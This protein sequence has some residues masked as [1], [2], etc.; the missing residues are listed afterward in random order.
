MKGSFL[1]SSMT[2]QGTKLE[3]TGDRSKAILFLM[4]SLWLANHGWYSSESTNKRQPPSFSI[5]V[6]ELTQKTA[7]IRGTKW[8]FLSVGLLRSGPRQPP[9]PAS[10]KPNSQ[11][12]FALEYGLMRKR[13]LTTVD[14]YNRRRVN[15][16]PRRCRSNL[17]TLNLLLTKQALDMFCVPTLQ[18]ATPALVFELKAHEEC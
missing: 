9:T 15:S 10:G 13:R 3:P 6:I 8:N 16:S 4:P 7:V 5:A 12:W 17:L 18:V 2:V 11:N 1:L 14:R